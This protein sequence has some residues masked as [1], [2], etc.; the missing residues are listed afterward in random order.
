MRSNATTSG[1]GS[2]HLKLNKFANAGKS[3]VHSVDVGIV[4]TARYPAEGTSGSA[5]TVAQVAVWNEFGTQG[6]GWGGPIPPRPFMRNTI[7]MSNR[8]ER[9]Q[10]A[11]RRGVTASS[12]SFDAR[13]AGRIGAIIH[14]NMI[15]AMQDPDL[16]PNS[17]ITIAIK[18]SSKPLH[19]TGLLRRSLSWRV[20]KTAPKDG[21]GGVKVVTS[22]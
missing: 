10:S 14:S 17:P 2:I 3:G 4:K 19:D 16:H 21:D 13:T 22:S 1:F 9:I 5:P 18:G 12:P 11:I 20:N 15:K 7:R 6:G 8:D